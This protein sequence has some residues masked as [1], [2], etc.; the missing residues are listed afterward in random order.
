MRSSP[1]SPGIVGDI[2]AVAQQLLDALDDHS[3]APGPPADWSAHPRVREIAAEARRDL[4][5]FSF[6]PAEM[7]Q[8]AR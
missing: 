4:E 6:Y 8:A 2:A 5:H 1:G 7:V 3:N